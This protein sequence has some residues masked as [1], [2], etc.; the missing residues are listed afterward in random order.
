MLYAFM[1]AMLMNVPTK[2]PFT[3]KLPSRER[4][5]DQS[6]LS[7]GDKGVGLALA[8]CRSILHPKTHSERQATLLLLNNH[9][10]LLHT[11]QLRKLAFSAEDA[12]FHA[13]DGA[14]LN[15]LNILVT[16]SGNFC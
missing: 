10:F 8:K 5:T 12:D 1:I 3:T 4:I 14:A 16:E 9:R 15:F 6:P 13:R 2:L 7:G 11:K